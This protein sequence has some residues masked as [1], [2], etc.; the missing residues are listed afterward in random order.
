MS[1]MERIPMEGQEPQL[2][3]ELR[4]LWEA[5]DDLGYHQ[6]MSCKADTVVERDLILPGDSRFRIGRRMLEMGTPQG[7]VRT[8]GGPGTGKTAFGNA[9]MGEHRRVD[10]YET[11]TEATLFGH[12]D[13]LGVNGYIPGRLQQHGQLDPAD[14]ALYLN[15]LPHLRNTRVFNPVWDG[16]YMTVGD[17]IIP[18]K[19]AAVYYTGN[20]PDGEKVHEF[21]ETTNSRTAAEI[22]TGD[23]DDAAAREIQGSGRVRKAEALLTGPTL[24]KAAARVALSEVV[25]ASYTDTE[26][27]IGNFTVDLIN[28]LNN[29]GLVE[30]IPT[31][32]ARIG[33]AL[34]R[35]TGA[36]LFSEGYGPRQM[37]PIHA[38]RVAALVMPTATRLSPIAKDNILEYIGDDDRRVSHLEAHIALRRIV[39]AKAMDVALSAQ[40]QRTRMEDGLDDGHGMV[41]VLSQADKDGVIQRNVANYSFANASILDYDIDKALRGVQQAPK[42]QVIERPRRFGLGY[43]RGRS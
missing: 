25:A 6:A 20:Y 31:T 15:E 27:V 16:E 18:I 4:E 3:G 17:V 36:Y 30:Q 38:A 13:P 9:V 37:S 1:A 40:G 2:E 12:M 23:M 14:P 29:T 28:A 10:I 11:D 35:A 39:A 43:I 8:I 7:S 21:D 26:N 22:L 19:R 41:G 33:Q 34:R 32:D 42:R 24:P 5:S